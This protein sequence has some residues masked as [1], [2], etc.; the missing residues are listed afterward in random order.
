MIRLFLLL[1]VLSVSAPAAAVEAFLAGPVPSGSL[2]V[3]LVPTE[4]ATPGTLRLVTFGVPFPRGSI[5]AAGLATLR[6]M[7]DGSEIPAHVRELTPWRH[8][9][10]PALDGTS[11][12]VARVQIRY[13]FAGTAP[14]TVTVSW[15][16]APRQNDVPSLEPVRN[17]WHTA[18]SGSF[19]AADNVQEPDVL[20]VLPASWLSLGA[21]RGSRNLPFDASNTEGRDNPA[22][23]AAIQHWSGH[24]EADRAMKNNFYASINQDDARVTAANQCRY[25]TEYEPWLY[26][27]ASTMFALYVRSGFAGAL[28]EAVRASDFYTDHVNTSGHFDMRNGDTK[29]VYAENLAYRY[30]LTGDDSAL[31]RLAAIVSAHDGFNEAWTPSMGFWTERH[32]A[33]K[34]LA[35]QVAYELLG[36][37]HAARVGTIVSRLVSHQNGANGQIPQPAGYV[38][39]GLYHFGSQHDGDW[40]S[41][42]LGASSW[43]SVLIVDAMLR[44]YSTSEDPAIADFVRR[45]GNFLRASTVL[46]AAHTYSNHAGA[47]ALPRYAMLWNGSNGQIND[48]DVEHSLDVATGLAWAHYFA[49]L[50]GQHD[51]RLAETAEDLYFTYDEGVNFWIRPNGPASGLPA[52]R[53]SPWRKFSWEH[54][55]SGGMGWA[56]QATIT[57]DPVFANGF[58]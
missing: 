9:L 17:G 54:R 52:Y 22:T 48:A 6:V 38:D 4:A 45:M 55:V 28:R 15:G 49:E 5:T 10:N 11:V 20:A 14:E 12:R 40:A 7:K 51:P 27:R 32:V 43:M 33:Y 31:D 19:I 56:M 53:T 21:L 3:K 47:L 26:D 37:N 29:Y 13:S 57:V 36:G 18:S 2:E 44:A 16:G 46:T 34:L 58:D 39:G 50:L 1:V 23:N 8:R 30:W 24:T 42:S 35:N 41:G 25:K